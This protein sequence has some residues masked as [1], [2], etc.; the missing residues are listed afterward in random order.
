[1]RSTCVFGASQRREGRFL[2]RDNRRLLLT[3]DLQALKACSKTEANQKRYWFWSETESVMQTPSL[4]W[5]LIQVRV[6]EDGTEDTRYQGS[7]GDVLSLMHRE[8]SGALQEAVSVR[9]GWKETSA[10]RFKL[11]MQG[12]WKISWARVVFKISLA[13]LT[14]GRWVMVI[15]GRFTASLIQK[16]FGQG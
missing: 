8:V 1:M 7:R 12:C 14:V 6:W 13:R 15:Q 11:L 9:Q 16:E 3:W 4:V 5:F 2:L 10:V